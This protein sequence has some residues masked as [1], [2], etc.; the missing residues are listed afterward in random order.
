[1]KILHTSDWHLGHTLYNFDRTEEQ[2]AMMVQIRNIIQEEQ[3]DAL[4][5][6]GDVYH[7]PSPSA[8][9]QTMFTNAIVSFHEA[10]P[11]MTIIITAGNHDSG[12]KHEIFRTPWRILNVYMIGSV[13]NDEGWE[14][15]HII[16]VKDKGYIIALPYQHERNMPKGI[17]Q[18]LLDETTKRNTRQLPVVMMAHTTVGGADFIGHDHSNERSVGGIDSLDIQDLGEGYDY[19]ALGHIHHAQFIQGSEHRVRYSGSPLAVS[20]DETYSHSI[21]IV[22]IASHGE[23][24]Q[25]RTIDINNPH[26]LVTLPTDGWT[27]WETAQQLLK[28]YPDDIPAYIRLNVEVDDFLP[29]SAQFDAAHIVENKD[30]RFCHINARRTLDAQKGENH[31][32]TVA[33]FQAENPIDIARRYAQDQGIAFDADMEKLFNEA[34]S[35]INK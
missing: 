10:C 22:E 19:L 14:N 35:E 18:T 21:S 29:A 25:V 28:G 7:T 23:F 12:S 8:A 16:E 20:F 9:I 17:F 24:P 30:C 5:L 4:L 31:I 26:P 13:S 33:E 1:M 15:E 2:L 11:T 27:D 32:M 3:P 6:C 34:L